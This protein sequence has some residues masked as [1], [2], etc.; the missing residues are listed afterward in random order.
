MRKP[1]RGERTCLP[2]RRVSSLSISAQKGVS[3]YLKQMLE[4]F[5]KNRNTDS[6]VI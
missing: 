1:A 4:A 5:K 3:T 6:G 2:M